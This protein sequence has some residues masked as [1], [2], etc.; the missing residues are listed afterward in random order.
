MR[1]EDIDWLCY[2]TLSRGPGSATVPDLAAAT[3]LAED[4]V[5]SSAARLERALLA[6]RDGDRILL[7]GVQDSLLLCQVRY[8]K[9][10]PFVVE[11]GVIRMRR[12]DD[13]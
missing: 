1:D 13:A 9:E 6:R 2:M 12:P 3:G 7:L 8:G 10:V 5:A 4:A 11:D